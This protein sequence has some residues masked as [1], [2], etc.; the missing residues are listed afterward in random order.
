MDSAE[1]LPAVLLVDDDE[2]ALLLLRKLFEK[3]K[4]PNPILAFRDGADA[5]DYLKP[6]CAAV[7]DQVRNIAVMLLDIKMP[8][9]SGFDVLAWVRAQPRLKNLPVVMLSTSDE[10]KDI[11]SANALG[12]QSY[13]L[14]FPAAETLAAL[15]KFSQ[16]A[17]LAS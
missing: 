9:L 1:T 10:P 7:G 2:E 8:R 15:V 13:L 16:L 14:K 4:V 3:A 11:E 12:A 6:A 5:I 17:S